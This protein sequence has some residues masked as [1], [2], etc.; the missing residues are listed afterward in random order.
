[1]LRFGLKSLDDIKG[2]RDYVVGREEREEWLRRQK[3][4]T[5][6]P[7]AT[8]AIMEVDDFK[9]YKFRL[10]KSWQKNKRG[11]MIVATSPTTVRSPLIPATPISGTVTKVRIDFC[12]NSGRLT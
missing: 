4:Q 7:L 11:E 9:P 6:R 2:A 10:H 1:M 5:L 12:R 8:D 3:E